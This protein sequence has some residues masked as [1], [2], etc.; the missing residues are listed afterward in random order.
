MISMPT[1]TKRPRTY[2]PRPCKQRDV[3]QLLR[4]AAFVLRMTQRVKAEILAEQLPKT[5]QD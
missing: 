3:E 2:T 4:D 5:S 1:K